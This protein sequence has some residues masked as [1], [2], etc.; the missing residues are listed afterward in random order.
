MGRRIIGF[1]KKDG[2]TRPITAKSRFKPKVRKQSLPKLKCIDCG[3][4]FPRTELVEKY[5]CTNCGEYFD[6][7]ERK[8]SCE[9][10]GTEFL[11][12]E[13]VGPGD[14]CPSCGE[15]GAKIIEEYVCPQCEEAM[16]KVKGYECP[17]CSSFNPINED[18]SQWQPFE[19]E[20]GGEED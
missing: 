2:K 17:S 5:S 3:K 15:G 9:K 13:S 19:E 18:G 4:R 20:G 11:E 7:F 6:D 14:V 12:R 16:E 10:C 1:Y 8:R